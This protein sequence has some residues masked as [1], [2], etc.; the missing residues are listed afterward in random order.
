MHNKKLVLGFII[1]AFCALTIL[2]GFTK[3]IQAAYWSYCGYCS[4]TRNCGANTNPYTPIYC[5]FRAGSIYGP[6]IGQCS[7]AGYECSPYGTCYC[8]GGCYL[9]AICGNPI[10]SCG[11]F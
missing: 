2:P 9:Y 6:L 4:G 8:G 7:G 10:Q 3:P 5:D 1:F 11:S